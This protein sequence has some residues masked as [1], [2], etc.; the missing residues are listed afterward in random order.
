MRAFK[1]FMLL[2]FATLVC[3]TDSYSKSLKR[4]VWANVVEVEKDGVSGK[5]ITT[6]Y[7]GKKHKVEVYRSILHNDQLEESPYFYADGK[8]SCKGNKKNLRIK[9]DLETM[10][11]EQVSC[12]GLVLSNGL[13]LYMPDESVQPYA[14][15][16]ELLFSANND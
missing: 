13:I 2:L 15:V 1:L 5:I 14:Y 10:M 6:L 7:L 16:S 4:T 12:S 8:Y 11:K 3:T 9:L